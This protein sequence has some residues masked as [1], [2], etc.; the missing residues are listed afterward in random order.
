MI[1]PEGYVVTNNHVIDG[2]DE[3]MV[4]LR[5]GKAYEASLI[6]ADPRTDLAL[7]KVE[8]EEPLPLSTSASPRAC[9]PATGW[10]RS[11]TLRS[12]W[13]GDRGYRL[14]RGRDLPGGSLIDFI[15]IDAPINRAIPAARPS[16][17]KVRS[18][19]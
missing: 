7:L 18:S 14:G 9:A 17:A 12:R 11:A 15:Q 8:A 5:D 16:T 13:L 6:G 19:V 3:I 1:D 2:A 4:T 10:W